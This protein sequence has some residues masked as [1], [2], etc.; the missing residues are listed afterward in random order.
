MTTDLPQ[1]RLVKPILVYWHCKMWWPLEGGSV[2]PMEHDTPI[3]D[4]RARRGRKRRVW[5][6]WSNSNGLE[7]IAYL[8][9]KVF[10]EHNEEDCYADY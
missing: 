7:G 10:L 9:R 6:C 1:R 8:S 2:C 3:Y 4:E 5:V